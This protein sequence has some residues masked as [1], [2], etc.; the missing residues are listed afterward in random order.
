MCY[1]VTNTTVKG[2][3]VIVTVEENSHIADVAAELIKIAR[4]HKL[5]A[6]TIL[7][8]VRLVVDTNTEEDDVKL[9]YLFLSHRPTSTSPD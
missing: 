3:R 7:N 1:A 9:S 5:V 8:G 2:E 4:E 6:E